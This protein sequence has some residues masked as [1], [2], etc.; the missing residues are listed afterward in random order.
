[1]LQWFYSSILVYNASLV[2][3]K[4]SI[5]LMCRRIF[6]SSGMQ[7]ATLAAILFLLAWGVSCVIMLAMIC[8]PAQKLWD[9]TVEGVCMPFV[10]VFFAPA[11]INMITDF[12]IFLLPRTSTLLLLPSSDRETD[13]AAP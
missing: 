1:M 3:V 11:C 7:K 4:I 5:V 8:V 9:P 6:V 13:Q 2:L 12:A 10:P